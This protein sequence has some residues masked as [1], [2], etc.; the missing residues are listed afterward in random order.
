MQFLLNRSRDL[1]GAAKAK[2]L[3]SRGIEPRS[4]AWQAVIIPLNQLRILKLHYFSFPRGPPPQYYRSA[5]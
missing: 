3:R 5:A 2:G 4:T 1:P